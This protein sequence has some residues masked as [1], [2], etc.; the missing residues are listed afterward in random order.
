MWWILAC[1][2]PYES[3]EEFEPRP[4]DS[5]Q[6]SPDPLMD[7]DAGFSTCNPIYP[8]LTMEAPTA[9]TAFLPSSNGWIAAAYAVDARDV[10]VRYNDGSWGSADQKGAVTTFWDHLT[11][12]PTSTTSSE[13]RLW[14]LY[15]GLR[16]DG[17]GSWLVNVPAVEQGYLPGTG[18]IRLRQ[19]VGDLEIE[20]SYF[21]PFQEGGE[22]DWV[23]VVT[24]K[25]VG[26]QAHTVEL[27]LL[28]NAHVDG[29]G[30]AAGEEVSGGR[31]G[32]LERGGEGAMLHSPLGS[33]SHLAAAPSGNAANP[34]TRLTGDQPLTDELISGDDVAV[35]FSWDFGSLAPGASAT[36]GGILSFDPNPDALSARLSSFIAGRSAEEILAAEEADWATWH[37]WE[38]PPASLSRDEL[39]LYRQS[40]A[41]LR[42]GQ[43]RTPG[44]GYG[45]ILA[46]LPP[47]IWNISWPRDQS[48]ATLA[49][50][51]AGHMAEAEAAVRFTLGSDSGYYADYLGLSD[52]AVSVARYYGDGKEESDGATCADGSDAGPNIELDD[53]GLFLQA[54]QATPG[55]HA[56]SLAQVRAGVADP[57]LSLIQPNDLLLPDSS[58][59]ERHWA[60]C[61]PNGRKQFVWSSLQAA[62]GLQ[63]AALDDVRYL[64]AA[65]RLRSGLLRLKANGGPVTVSDNGHCPVLASSPE[66]ICTACGPL[67]A[68]GVE[69]INQGLVR[70]ESA[71][72]EGTLLALTHL[73]AP[74]GGFKRNDDGTGSTNPY[75]W[76]DD[77]EWLFI[78]LRMAMAMKTVAEATENSALADS[79]EALLGHVTAVGTANHGLIPELLSD[80]V[81]T[82]DDDADRWTPG[83][84]GGGE[85]QGAHPMVGF[86]AG[87]YVLALEAMRD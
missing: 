43:V 56:E 13:D 34:W 54:W 50:V 73:R 87:A 2:I 22:R 15:P 69:I 20:T 31:S 12:N 17:E 24:V 19:L 86:G 26:S 62:A 53:W 81:Y 21:A 66:E 14:D 52:Y 42:M 32:I 68:S 5:R 63:A 82:P 29:E 36:R 30:S 51:A 38:N 65:A 59:W 46:S 71:I 78:D 23:T 75:P 33:P 83:V 79:A 49:L 16:V 4:I 80:G 64:D 74:S 85:A 55:V 18:I 57:L 35:G 60:D 70:P 37:R 3:G 44:S 84:D 76:Y 61:F 41:V 67:D 1:C 8:V 9:S 45:Q 11:K 48:F 28:Q 47:G 7:D 27:Y 77:Q 6:D 72:A 25:N 58:I 39:A 40:T 10:P